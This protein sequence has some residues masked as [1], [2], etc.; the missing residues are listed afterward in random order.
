MHACIPYRAETFCFS[1]RYVERVSEVLQAFKENGPYGQDLPLDQSFS[2]LQYFID[3]VERI[4]EQ[5]RELN[6]RQ[7]LLKQP[8]TR[9]DN[10]ALLQEEIISNSKVLEVFN[11]FSA[12][13]AEVENET[14]D[15]ADLE[16]IVGKIDRMSIFEFISSNA[17]A[18]AGLAP[19]RKYRMTAAWN[20][21]SPDRDGAIASTRPTSGQLSLICSANL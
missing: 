2:S 1:F 19:L 12:T 17:R 15:E 11:T 7:L 4:K 16:A 13:V 9:F 6:R 3:R 8:I 10:L 21:S 20:L 14:F 18:A 5:G